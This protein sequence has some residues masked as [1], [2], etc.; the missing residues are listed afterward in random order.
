MRQWYIP[1]MQLYEDRGN[2]WMERERYLL[3]KCV[4]WLFLQLSRQC[5]LV[6]VQIHMAISVCQSCNPWSSMRMVFISS[7]R[8]K[9]SEEHSTPRSHK[10]ISYSRRFPVNRIQSC[11]IDSNEQFVIVA[12]FRELFL[13]R[14]DIWLTNC[15]Q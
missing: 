2:L 13:S 1:E 7:Q 12:H 4:S 3:H 8:K 15:V 6:L 14:Q 11:G 5:R 9:V 10:R